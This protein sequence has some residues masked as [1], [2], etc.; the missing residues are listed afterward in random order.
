M[1]V[2]IIESKRSSPEFEARKPSSKMIL[3]EAQA[4]MTTI[5]LMKKKKEMIPTTIL[6]LMTMIARTMIAMMELW[7]YPHPMRWN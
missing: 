1:D 5:L 6:L 7:L 2:E 3:A 4:P